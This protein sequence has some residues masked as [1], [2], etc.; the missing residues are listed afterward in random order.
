MKV[1]VLGG[2]PAGLYFA[3]SMK[4]RD[5][6]HDITV[7]ERN[8]PDDTFGWG[9]VLSDETLDN[10][11]ENDP[12]SAERIR[13][14]FAYWD[15]IAVVHKGVRTLSTGHG[16]CGIGRMRLLILLQ[17]RA[18]ELGIRLEFETEIDDPRPF[19]AEYDMVLASDGLNS[20]T[21]TTFAD[22]FKPD[23]DV[24]KCKFVW[25]GTHQKFDDAFTFIFE[26]TEHG[27]VWAHAYQFDDDTATFIVECGPE[28]WE[29]FGFG[30]MGQQESIAVCE[31]IFKDHLGGHKLMTNANHIRG[32]AW[33]NF[34]R[35]LCER[36]SHENIALMG[37]AAASAHFSI[38]SGTKLAL[39]SAIALAEYLHTE[40]TLKE[41]F[42]KYE[43]A[44]R[45]EVLRLQSAARN[46]L[47]W[48]EE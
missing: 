40:P 8:R 32:S 45:L 9:V 42:D 2:G 27:W 20:R 39:E 5:A 13:E 10:L 37:D 11:A 41:A 17:E 22:V 15:D 48:F 43:D 30:E 47:E 35:V 1:A 26:K 3:I 24:R 4:L 14:H 46:S 38:G 12:V 19:M 23:I 34:P 28:T 44:R 21:R 7:F 33:I 36:W 31:R 18:R 16:F 25:L 29:K 6:A